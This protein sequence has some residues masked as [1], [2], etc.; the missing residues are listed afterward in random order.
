MTKLRFWAIEAERPWRVL[1]RLASRDVGVSDRS[2]NQIHVDGRPRVV[3]QFAVA[4][5]HTAQT[6]QHRMDA[7][8]AQDHIVVIDQ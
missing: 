4:N 8:G 5:R 1:V 2:P 3:E 6:L 7:I